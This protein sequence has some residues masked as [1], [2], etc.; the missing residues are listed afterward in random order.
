VDPH[1]LEL[2][3]TESIFMHDLDGARETLLHLR[4]MG[5]RCSIDDFGTGYSGLTYLSQLPIYSLKIDQSFIRKIG[6]SFG[7]DHVVDAV[8]TLARGL[9]MKVIAEGVETGDQASFLSARGC[10]QMQ[11]LLFSPPLA[12]ADLD[13]LLSEPRGLWQPRDASTALVPGPILASDAH[14]FG[15]AGAEDLGALLNA[16]CTNQ[17]FGAIDEAGVACVLASLQPVRVR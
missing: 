16:V 17:G 3:I 6:T 5:V 4:N 10:D 2:E 9:H 12:R 7:G 11:G 13:E 1:L 8:I 14:A 15:T